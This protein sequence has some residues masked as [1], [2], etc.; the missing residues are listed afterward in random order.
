MRFVIT[1]LGCCLA[2]GARGE[3]ASELSL[4]VVD[5]TTAAPLETAT[6]TLEG[7]THRAGPDG[8]LEVRLADGPVALEVRAPGYLDRLVDVDGASRSMEVA[9]VPRLDLAERVEVRASVVPDAAGET[10][11]RP[12]EVR[13]AAGGGENVF[14]LLQTLPGVAGPEDWSNRIAVRGGGPDENL[15]VMDG[16]EIHNP[17]RLFGL[18]SAFNPETAD[19]FEL[20]TGGFSAAHGDRLSSLLIVNNRDG[21]EAKALAGTAALSLTDANAILEGR[22]PGGSGSWLLSGRRTYYDLVA[23]RFVDQDLPSFDDVQARLSMRLGGGRT[24]TVFGLR[25][26]EA[27]DASFDRPEEGANGA[28]F[29]RTRNDVVAA[30]FAGT[31]RRAGRHAH[32]RLRLH[33]HGRGRFRRGL[34]QRGAALERAR[35]ARPSPAAASNSPGTATVRDHALRQELTLQAGERHAAGGR[36][37]AAP[38]AHARPLHD[39]RRAQPHRQHLEP[40]RRRGPAGR[41]GLVAVVHA[42][43]GLAAGPRQPLL[44]AHP[45][46][47][48]ALRP[49]LRERAHATWARGSRGRGRSTPDPAAARGL[50]RVHAEPGLREARPGRLTSWTSRS[51]RRA[52]STASG[53]ATPSSGWSAT[54]RAACSAASRCITRRSTT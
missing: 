45:A 29:S 8:R 19:D 36:G 2:L 15:T 24:L 33:E 21:S 25:S 13:T 20:S 52:A 38:P 37:R 42:P 4:R 9:L 16:V 23:E 53:R 31:A 3:A 49:Q 11:V 6:V 44:A 26:R 12:D 34:P 27:S 48:P 5:A 7:R 41:A 39:P 18:T 17:Y 50:G 10:P 22:L 1:L 30:T 35:R 54:C 40:G 46:G 32:D 47:R 51:R 43:R 28:F 14:R